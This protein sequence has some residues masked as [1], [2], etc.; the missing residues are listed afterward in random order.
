MNV[1]QRLLQNMLLTLD[2]SAAMKAPEVLMC[3]YSTL[4][5]EVEVGLGH[6][7]SMLTMGICGWMYMLKNGWERRQQ[8]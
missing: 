7:Q 6:A 3:E 1:Y 4:A 8:A 2:A 5:V